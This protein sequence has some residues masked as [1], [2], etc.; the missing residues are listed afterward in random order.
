MCVVLLMLPFV[1][2]APQQKVTVRVSKA[3]VQEV[4]RQI[5]EQA[6]LNFVY[7]KA[8]VATLPPV[9]LTMQR[10]TVDAVLKR[11]FQG[12]PFEYIYENSTVVIKKRATVPQK[13][14]EVVIRGVVSDQDGNTIPGVSVVLKGTTLGTASDADG[15]FALA[16]PSLD[17]V[18]LTF[19]WKQIVKFI[20][21]LDRF[22]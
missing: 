1:G 19:T 5:K 17:G 6:G 13:P 11:V 10:V 14:G 20:F 21:C 9:T 15:K 3:G 18:V 8:Q 2:R 16:L 4:F 7:D 12:S 22:S